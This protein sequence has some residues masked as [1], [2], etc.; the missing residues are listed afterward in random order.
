MTCLW[1]RDYRVDEILS[2]SS[3]T[4]AADNDA[5]GSSSS[6]DAAEEGSSSPGSGFAVMEPQPFFYTIKK[7]YP[8]ALCGYA[9]LSADSAP[10][11][12]C[13][14]S[15][16]TV[17]A[18][19]EEATGG[20][21]ALRRLHPI[22]VERVGDA[23]ANLDALLGAGVT[24]ESLLRHYA[25]NQEFM[26]NVVAPHKA[27][28][29]VSIFDLKGI[30][31]KGMSGKGVAVVRAV[32]N[33]CQTHYMERSYRIYLVNAPYWFAMTWQTLRPLLSVNTQKK[34]N[35]LAVGAFDQLFECIDRGVMPACY[36]GTS[37][38]SF[39]ESDQERLLCGLVDAANAPL[40]RGRRAGQRRR[41]GRR[42]GRRRR[43]RGGG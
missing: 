1:R 26:W 25:L 16:S 13:S 19:D 34:V 11:D 43:R 4:P 18:D 14:A 15:G 32:M 38:R 35:I 40:L 41:V 23:L 9:R 17:A 31:V 28:R 21:D 29:C 33:M 42:R 7:Y 12:D 22:Y 37:E 6:A 20:D 10:S 3:A 24:Q 27:S 30:S 36:G 2:K 5:D 8:H 39:G